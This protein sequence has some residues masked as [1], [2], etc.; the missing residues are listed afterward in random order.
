[1]GLGEKAGSVHEIP[2]HLVLHPRGHRPA[3]EARGRAAVGVDRR[4]AAKGVTA[5]APGRAV[6]DVLDLRR[7]PTAVGR[8]RLTTAPVRSTER[9]ARGVIP[10]TR[11]ELAVW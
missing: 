11:R 2:E 6:V 7:S 1:M 10:T 5:P 8:R 3:P 9:P 4:S